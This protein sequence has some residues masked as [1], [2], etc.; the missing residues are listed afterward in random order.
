M[1]TSKKEI[2]LGDERRGDDLSLLSQYR[3]AKRGIEDLDREE[4]FCEEKKEMP[5]M[6]KPFPYGRDG[7]GHKR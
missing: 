5:K 4:W 2:A 3:F 7:G 6:Q 1:D